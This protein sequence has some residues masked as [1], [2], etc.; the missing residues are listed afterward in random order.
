MFFLIPFIAALIPSL[1]ILLVAWWFG[2]RD[3]PMF[4]RILPGILLSVA[5]IIIF[6]ISITQIRGFEGGV[7]GILSFTLIVFG[8]ISFLIGIKVPGNHN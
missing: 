7:Y 8:I 6:Y 3:Y 2:K 1:I 4:I 5:A